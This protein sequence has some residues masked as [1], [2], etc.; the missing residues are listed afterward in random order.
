MFSYFPFDPFKSIY[1]PNWNKMYKKK[2]KIL[3]Q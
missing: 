2:P 1:E 3:K